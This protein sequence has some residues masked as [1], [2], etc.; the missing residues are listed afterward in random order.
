M[1]EKLVRQQQF[2]ALC[3][4]ILSLRVMPFIAEQ[5]AVEQPHRRTRQR[6]FSFA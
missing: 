4:F 6:V 1:V 5:Q 3:R 2:R